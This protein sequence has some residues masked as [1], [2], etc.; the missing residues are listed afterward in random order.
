MHIQCRRTKW[1]SVHLLHPYLRKQ[2]N[3]SQFILLSTNIFRT[4]F[5]H[6]HTQAQAYRLSVRHIGLHIQFLP[7]F[8][9]S[10]MMLA[11]AADAVAAI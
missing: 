5:I 2:A 3:K 1:F 8:D 9:L 4:I 10:L 11:A 6:T 7:P